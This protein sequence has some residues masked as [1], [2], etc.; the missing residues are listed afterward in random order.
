M[1]IHHPSLSLPPL[2][3]QE[4]VLT[5]VEVPGQYLAGCE[6]TPEST[7][8]LEGFSSNVVIVRRHSSSCRRLSLLCSD[9][10]T[11]HML[12]QTGQNS[13]QVRR[14]WGWGVKGR[15]NTGISEGGGWRSEM[16]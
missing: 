6:V 4:M 15:G 14:T 1:K 12:V 13:N 8:Y 5:D 3:V 9:G 11:R 16:W 10:K 2:F 7:V